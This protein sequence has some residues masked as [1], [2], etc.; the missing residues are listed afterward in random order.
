MSKKNSMQTK[1]ESAEAG[2]QMALI[3]VAPKNAK[4]I[5]AEARIY[6]RLM[7]TR[8][9]A[10]DKEKAQKVKVLS[11]VR[12]AKIEPLEDGVIRFSYDGFT[13]KITPR[14]ELIQVTEETE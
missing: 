8:K 12:D 3:D 10:G 1:V 2:K 14:D 13:I 9:K 6:R 11:L 4:P 5:I 7:L